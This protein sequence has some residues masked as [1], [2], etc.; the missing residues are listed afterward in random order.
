MKKTVRKTAGKKTPVSSSIARKPAKRIANKQVKKTVKK[1]V[2]KPAK[3]AVKIVIKA[4]KRK[5]PLARKSKSIAVKKPAKAIEGKLAGVITHYFSRVSAAVIKLLIP[6]SVG[7]NIKV[8]GHTSDFTQ[9]VTS[10]QIDRTVVQSAKV[11]DIIG[12][13]VKSRVR[14]GDLVTKL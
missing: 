8:K 2:S 1:A 12:L 4:L 13:Q 10:M 11:G 6:L 9:Q 7:D 3:K 5:S 14:R